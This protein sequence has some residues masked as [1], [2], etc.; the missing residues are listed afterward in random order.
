MDS[1]ISNLIRDIE[2]QYVEI[3]EHAKTSLTPDEQNSL[4]QKLLFAAARVSFANGDARVR[5]FSDAEKF[6]AHF[7]PVHFYSPIPSINEIDKTVYDRRYDTI[8]G[9]EISRERHLDTLALLSAYAHEMADFPADYN[10]DE[11]VYFW[12]NTAFSYGDA[13]L[14]YCLIRHLKPARIIEIG[15]GFSTFLAAQALSRN[16]FG[17]MVCVEP[18]PMPKLLKLV[19]RSAGVV[20]LVESKVQD[21]DPTIFAALA[22]NDILFID[23]S[24]VSKVGSDVNHEVFTILPKVSTGVWC[25]VHDIF[26]PWDYAREWVERHQIFWNEQY[27]IMAFLAF[28]NSFQ[29]E[30][31]NQFVD[32]ELQGECAR[33]F[34]GTGRSVFGGSSLWFRRV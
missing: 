21:A 16:G 19:E 14:Y 22:A 33:L 18:Y 31:A 5:I 24:H 12:N 29:I 4:C 23:S 8:P 3:A 28:N 15:S 25:H 26:F 6:G 2:A 1:K 20:R 32:R 34:A 30:I 7:L 9:L 27:L 17:E 13:V 10:G 11:P